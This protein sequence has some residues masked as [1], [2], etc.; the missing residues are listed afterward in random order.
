MVEIDKT[1]LSPPV[2]VCVSIIGN[3]QA[4]VALFDIVIIVEQC[5]LGC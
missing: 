4:T 1:A 2:C 3:K 5:P